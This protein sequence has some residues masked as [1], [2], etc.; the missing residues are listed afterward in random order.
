[1]DKITDIISYLISIQNNVV[2]FVIFK[3]TILHVCHR[4]EG[5]SSRQFVICIEYAWNEVQFYLHHV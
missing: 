4:L 3:M 2:I 5:A 1:M